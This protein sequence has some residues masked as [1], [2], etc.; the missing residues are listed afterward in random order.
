MTSHPLR[1]SMGW[2]QPRTRRG[3]G[4]FVR[5][6]LPPPGASFHTTPFAL[7]RLRGLEVP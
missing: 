3:A 7:H 1:S 6:K 4:T 5:P 2:P